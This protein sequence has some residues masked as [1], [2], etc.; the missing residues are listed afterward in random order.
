MSKKNDYLSTFDADREVSGLYD[1]LRI[2][3]DVGRISDFNAF[4]STDLEGL[5][6]KVTFI[7]LWLGSTAMTHKNL[8]K[9][10]CRLCSK[11][12]RRLVKNIDA[13]CSKCD[14][15]LVVLSVS[16]EASVRYTEETARGLV[17][18]QF[19]LSKKLQKDFQGFVSQEELDAYNA[20]YSD[21]SD[22]ERCGNCGEHNCICIS[23]DAHAEKLKADGL[24]REKMLANLAKARAAKV[25]KAA[26]LKTK[27]R[28]DA[29]AIKKIAKSKK[30]K[31]EKEQKAQMYAASQA[32][33]LAYLEKLGQHR[34]SAGELVL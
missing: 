34:R 21:G 13:H 20:H 18:S 30:L 28:E 6:L 16:G 2:I 12:T 1:F 22:N 25:A 23:L 29:A 4:P 31:D 5:T 24:K 14:T 7:R 19:G 11:T 33:M 15:P 32:S 10:R 8:V 26:A 3:D 27:E 9:T 17:L